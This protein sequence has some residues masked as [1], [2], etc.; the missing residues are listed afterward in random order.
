MTRTP[1]PA[2]RT[3]TAWLRWT[4]P[5][6]PGTE[7]AL[8]LAPGALLR[9]VRA[10]VVASLVGLVVL[11]GLLA[12]VASFDAISQ[13]AVRQVAWPTRLR[14]VPPLLVDSFTLAGTLLVVWISLSARAHQRRKAAAYG[15]LLVAVGTAA[16]VIINLDHAPDTLAG[17]VVA[18]SPPVALLLAIEALVVVV[19]Y[20]LSDL[21]DTAAAAADVDQHAHATTV[22][23]RAHASTARLDAPAQPA[24]DARAV[25]AA[26]VS[27][28]AAARAPDALAARTDPAQGALALAAPRAP[29]TDARPDTRSDA[30]TDAPARGG[31]VGTAQVRARVTAAWRAREVDGGEQLVAAELARELGAK[32][33]RVQEALRELRTHQQQKQEQQQ[34]KGKR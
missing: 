12:F 16:S 29:R 11:I 28:R 6:A 25:G 7:T 22:D 8:A 10:L 27:A 2:E 34:E 18:G 23:G 17:R 4:H 3:L 19:R 21:V 26:D 13:Y 31:T 30:R 32:P 33:R 5:S 20:L 15:W 1:A 14:W 24:L 9:T